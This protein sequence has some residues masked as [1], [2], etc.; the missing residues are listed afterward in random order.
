MWWQIG[1]AVA[2]AAVLASMEH[3][4]RSI[5]MAVGTESA[6]AIAEVREAI[7]VEVDQAATKIIEATGAD[8][9]TAAEIRTLLDPV[10][11]IVPD[12]AVDNGGGDTGGTAEPGTEGGVVADETA[13]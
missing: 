9:D 6:K 13:L 12:A 5:I 2:L 4:R 7:A 8:A 3:S 11:G 10:K 1:G